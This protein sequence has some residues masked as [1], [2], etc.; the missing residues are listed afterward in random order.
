MWVEEHCSLN[1]AI[2]I[3]RCQKLQYCFPSLFHSHLLWLGAEGKLVMKCLAIKMFLE[4]D[5][6]YIS[7]VFCS[8]APFYENRT[9]LKKHIGLGI[10]AIALCSRPAWVSERN[11]SSVRVQLAAAA[12]IWI[13]QEAAVCT[14]WTL[15]EGRCCSSMRWCMSWHCLYDAFSLSVLVTPMDLKQGWA[16]E[17]FDLIF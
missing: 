16:L 11:K 6:H 14:L 15:Q 4:E 12:F 17:P 7:Y 1:G 10:K 5:V 2:K 8:D 9:F 3:T 13:R